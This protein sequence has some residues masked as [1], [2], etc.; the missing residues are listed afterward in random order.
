MKPS[1]LFICIAVSVASQGAFAGK[2][3]KC[4][5]SSGRTYMTERP[6]GDPATEQNHLRSTHVAAD[7]VQA[8]GIFS[9]RKEINRPPASPELIDSR[10][11]PGAADHS[12]VAP[13]TQ[14]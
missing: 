1:L 14:D 7:E 6:C 10:G 13:K 8:K 2:V 9:A 3:N 4:K 12:A 11:I 5:D